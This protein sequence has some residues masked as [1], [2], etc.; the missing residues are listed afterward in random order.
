MTYARENRE[1]AAASTLWIFAAVFIIIF[2]MALEHYESLIGI[3]GQLVKASEICDFNINFD[4]KNLSGEEQQAVYLLNEALKNYQAATE[5]DLIKYRLTS[6]AAGIAHW[7]MFIVNGDV[8]NPGN[9]VTWS[10]EFRDMLGFSSEEDFPNILSSWIDRLHPDDR[11]RTIAAFL[12]SI[13][14]HKGKTPYDLEYRLMMKSGEYRYFRAFGTTMRDSKG[15]PIRIAGALE[16]ITDKKLMQ[17]KTYETEERIKLMIKEAPLAITLWDKNRKIID[18]SETTLKIFEFKSKQE[19]IEKFNLLM[20]EYQPDGTLSKDKVTEAFSI[21]FSTGYCHCEWWHYTVNGELVPLD[22]PLVRTNYKDGFAVIAY[23]RDLRKEKEM[24]QKIEQHNNLVNMSNT[25]ANV[26]LQTEEANFN[27]TITYCMEMMGKTIDAD[28]VSMWINGIKDGKLHCTQIYEWLRNANSRANKGV[29]AEMSYDAAISVWEKILS[30]GNCVNNFVED[31]PA[32][33]QKLMRS[34]NIRF[35]FISPLF[36]HEHFWGF[37]SFVHCGK[38]RLLDKGEQDILHSCGTMITSALLRHE[39]IQNVNSANKAKS[40]FL[41]NMSHEMRTPLNAIIGMIKISKSTDDLLRKEYALNRIEDASTNLLNVINDILDMSKIEANKLELSPVEFNIEKMLQKAISVV[42]FKIDEKQQKISVAADINVPRFIVCD[43]QR[44]LQVITNL[45]SNANKFT[46]EKGKIALKVSLTEEKNGICTLQFEIAD[47]GIG[48]SVEQQKRLFKPFSQAESGTSRVFGGTGLGLALSRRIVELMGGNIWIESELGKG[49]KFFFTIKTTRGKQTLLSQLNPE[50][51]REDLTILA[52]DNEE[53]TRGYFKTLF[54]QL[55]ITCNTARG[56][57][58]ALRMIEKNGAYGIYFIE[59]NDVKGI[60]LARQIKQAGNGKKSV[61]TLISDNWQTIREEAAKAGVNRYL[62][63]P[64][65]TSTIIECVNAYLDIE[66][67]LQKESETSND[68]FTRKKLLLAEDIDINREIVITLLSGT[69]ISIDE[70]KNGQEALKKIKAN[71]EK[72][73]VIFMDMQMPV[74]DGLEATRR[75]RAFEETLKKK[76]PKRKEI[77][78]IAMT[79]NVF[80]EDID[81][82]IAAGMN[83]HLGKPLDID[84]VLAVL[85]KYCT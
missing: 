44:L 40:D 13:N 18:C 14:D 25:V 28:R 19:C 5:Y 63:K 65:F 32:A 69:G 82:C 49:A 26:L 30:S 16:D 17:Q 75:I 59:M 6:K 35:L 43:D 37:M 24:S 66:N 10:Q 78:V 79:A 61:I 76:N 27:K 36:V 39:M 53:L 52:V 34:R 51:K 77:P 41:A 12:G 81:N 72:Y 83:G 50:I 67:T 11:E 57:S 7:D 71:P 62:M 29:T 48:I 55:G 3:L 70:A 42:S 15:L 58:E 2:S 4:T 60:E 68:R 1:F 8:D 33:E 46:Q 74:M 20:P 84:E 73:D 38:G 21:A 64:L 22:V 54:E 9:I 31:V 47:N 80:K 85:R 56:A 23:A 45:L